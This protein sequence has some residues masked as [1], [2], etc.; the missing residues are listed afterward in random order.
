MESFDWQYESFP[1]YCFSCGIIE[2]SSIECNNPIERDEEGKL[3]YSAD[4]ICAPDERRKKPQS[5]HSLS[6][7]ASAGQGR[8]SSPAKERPNQSGNNSGAVGK[9]HHK[10]DATEVSSSSKM[11]RARANK[12]N[13]GKATG[14]NKE[15]SQGGKALIGQK[16]KSVQ[17]Y[18]QKLPSTLTE[19]TGNPLALVVHQNAQVEPKE[20]CD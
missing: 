18:R 19:D 8:P 3:P 15:S 4:R 2:H 14:K 16:M 7:S 5:T 13:A 11:P 20:Y 10:E 12:T 17:V 1:H 6:G 9:Q